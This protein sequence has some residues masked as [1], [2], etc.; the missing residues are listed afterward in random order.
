MNDNRFEEFEEDTKREESEGQHEECSDCCCDDDC[1]C[2][3]EDGMTLEEVINAI[4]REDGDAA[5]MILGLFPDDLLTD[6]L[7]KRG[8]APKKQRKPRVVT[9]KLGRKPTKKAAKTTAKASAKTG[10]K[11]GPGRPPKAAAAKTVRASKKT[12]T[13]KRGP[14]RP[15]K[16]LSR[17]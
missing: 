11:R 1:D 14:G 12:T 7:E 2:D 10:A 17:R 15:R 4:I 3:D 8:M 6:E 9:K 13:A 16:K 5:R